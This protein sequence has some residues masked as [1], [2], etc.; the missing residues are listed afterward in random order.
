MF[1]FLKANIADF[2]KTEIIGVF[3]IRSRLWNEE[4][5]FKNVDFSLWDNRNDYLFIG[6]F[7]PFL[8]HYYWLSIRIELLRSHDFF[9]KASLGKNE[10]IVMP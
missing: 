3:K 9:V 2:K 6:L 8:A 5:F 1:A 7:F 10:V 4:I